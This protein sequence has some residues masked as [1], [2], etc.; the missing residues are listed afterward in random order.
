MSQLR[1]Y[2]E[3]HPSETQ[4]LLGI[5]YGQLIELIINAENLY[6]RHKRH[7]ENQ[8]IRIIKAGS[9]RP[10]KLTI[11]D[12]ILLTLV[13]LHHL[14]TFQILGVQFGI[15]ESTA[16]YIFHRWVKIL[17][18]L[19]PASLLEQ[20]KKNDS[21]LAWVLEILK[22]FE[23]IVDSYEQPLQRPTDYQEQ[24]KNYSGKQ[25]RHT[26]K[27][28]VIVMPSGKEIVDV[29]VGETGA[30]VDIKIWSQQRSSLEPSQRFQGDK[31]YVGE[32]LINTPHKKPRNRPLTPAQNR[33]NKTK[34]QKRIFVEHLIR[35]LKIFRVAAERFRLKPKNYQPVILVVCGLIR[36]RIGAI[37]MC[38]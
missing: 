15:G 7:Q 33:E 31:A 1:E 4:R 6:T 20:V 22:E 14:P 34:A 19:L 35:L 25:K 10:P 23:L 11:A 26:K 3:K 8:K 16:N 32:P 17:R 30:T 36:W 21:D 27:N 38:Q 12:Q 28:Q 13:Y 24:K 29:V 37:V 2:I 5:D 18:E 9:G